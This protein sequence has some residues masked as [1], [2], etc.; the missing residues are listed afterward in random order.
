MKTKI[1]YPIAPP[2]IFVFQTLL[3]SLDW[4]LLAVVFYLL[5]PTKSVEFLNYLPIFFMAQIF[6]IV[7]H[8]PA[9]AGVFDSIMLFYFKPVVGTSN[10]VSWLILFRV[11]YF[12]VPLGVG[13]GL[14]LLYEIYCARRL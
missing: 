1:L 13:I 3:S 4:I 12:L 10:L 6:A 8:V 2:K 5:L 11:I 7:S 14:F 9:G